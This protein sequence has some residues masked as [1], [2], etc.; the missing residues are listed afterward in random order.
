MI[1]RCVLLVEFVG[2]LVL[3]ASPVTAEEPAAP[4]AAAQLRE[5]GLV[6]LNRR[7]W[8]LPLEAQLQA[9]LKGLGS[10]VQRI[11]SAEKALDEQIVRNAA[12]WNE[13]SPAIEALQKQIAELPTSDPQRGPLE[14]QLDA[15]L[16]KVTPPEALAGRDDVR[17]ELARLAQDRCTLLVDLTFVRDAAAQIGPLYERLAEDPAVAA[18]LGQV[19]EKARLGPARHYAAEIRKLDELDAVAH[20]PHAPLYLQSGRIR[21]TAAA[22][23]ACL[24]FTFNPA[25]DAV[26]YLPASAAETA[27][28]E[29]PQDAPRQVVKIADRQLEVRRVTLGSVRL[30]SC[31]ARDVVAYVLP[32]EAEDLGAQLAARSLSPCNPRVD[33]ARLRL[34]LD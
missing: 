22:G 18:L 19:G 8:G 2:L 9:R 34:I 30:G 4:R 11:V 13:S 7:V 6:R 27:G 25:S 21:V 17:I 24:T 32:P 3:A 15:L 14:S 20:A 10:L 26:T 29:V 16:A 1:R 5:M 23:D 31:A 28:I 33:L 12:A